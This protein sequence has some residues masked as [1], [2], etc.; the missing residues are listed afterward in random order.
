ML[1][2]LSNEVIIHKEENELEFLQFKELLNYPNLVHCFTTRNEKDFYQQ[3]SSALGI[4]SNNLVFAKQVHGDIIKH[5]GTENRGEGVGK[6]RPFDCDGLITN[7]SDVG[8]VSVYADCVPVLFYDND[9][10]VIAMCHAG[11]RG[12]VKKIACKT[13]KEMRDDYACQ[14]ENIVVCIGPS[15][16]PCCFEVDESV[17]E[18]F[19]QAFKFWPQ[20]INETAEGR[21]RI[22]L[23]KA[24]ALQLQEIGV[25]EGNIHI[26]GLCTVCN[27]DVFYSYRV[28]KEEA[29]RI[30]AI[31]Y[32]K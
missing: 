9:K 1:R 5:V 25:K 10:K 31:M 7:K 30:K 11:W 17:A 4:D 22:D 32:L 24:N 6:D 21:L 26:A 16:G 12:T 14:N 2:N 18:E 23:W 8:L 15:I 27:H 29:G 19:K 28:E 3:I 13:L 20:I